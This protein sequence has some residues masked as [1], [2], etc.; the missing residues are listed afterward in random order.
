VIEG[1]ERRSNIVNEQV[2]LKVQ[3]KIG[4][5]WLLTCNHD[6][7]HAC[8]WL[9]CC[10]DVAL[11]EKDESK[12]PKSRLNAVL[13]GRSRQRKVGTIYCSIYSFK[14]RSC[15]HAGDI[16]VRRVCL[17]VCF[18]LG[19]VVSY[20]LCDSWKVQV[21]LLSWNASEMLSFCAICQY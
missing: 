4:Y 9:L 5:K 15:L 20:V 14:W 18:L 6:S 3:M 8:P 16:V 19:S 10:G 17:F 21:I 12:S 13:G 11:K 7:W 2:W 1:N